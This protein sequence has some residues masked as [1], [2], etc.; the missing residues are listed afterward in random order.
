MMLAVSVVLF[1][2]GALSAAGAISSRLRAQ[3]GWG[4][5]PG[6]GRPISRFGCVAAAVSLW[7][8]S[9]MGMVVWLGYWGEY[10]W[11]VGLLVLG[12][13]LLMCAAEVRDVRKEATGDGSTP[14]HTGDGS[15]EDDDRGPTGDS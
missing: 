6:P 13:L 14:A 15:G 11:L 8:F 9:A 3:F 4:R 5:G 12:G 10:D 7:T 2:I 1:V